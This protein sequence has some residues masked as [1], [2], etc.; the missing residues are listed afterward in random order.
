LGS[1]K[2]PSASW[3]ASGLRA[4]RQQGADYDI[5]ATIDALA[6]LGRANRDL[7]RE[8]NETLARLKI[9][10]LPSPSPSKAAG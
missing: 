9:K 3:L 5:A 1:P 10:R 4:A 6:S 2:R 8:R 7:L